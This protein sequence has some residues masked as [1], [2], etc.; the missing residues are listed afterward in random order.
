MK[1]YAVYK[2][3]EMLALGTLQEC[4]TKLNVKPESIM[5]YKTPTYLRRT[6]EET[7]RRLVEL[8]VIY[9]IK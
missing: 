8:G 1:E 2:G 4:A 6:N 5:Y 9:E 3:D 7:G